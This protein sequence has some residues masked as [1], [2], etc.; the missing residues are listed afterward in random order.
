MEFAF[1]KQENTSLK[2]CLGLGDSLADTVIN[3]I[4]GAV[5]SKLIKM[6]GGCV[7]QNL[8]SMTAPIIAT[9]Y[10]DH[11]NAWEEV[12]VEKR[13]EALEYVKLGEYTVP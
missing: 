13:A 10:L 2:C 6:P 9:H 1:L 4:G 3:S 8:V 11:A 7:E 5:L 12:G